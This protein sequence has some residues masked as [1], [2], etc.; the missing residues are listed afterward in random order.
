MMSGPSLAE[1]RAKG[2]P[3]EVL[4]RLNDEHWAVGSTCAGCPRTPP[5]QFA[6]L[7]WSPNAVTVCFM[8]SGAAAGVLTAVPGLRRGGRGGPADPALPA[9]RLLRRGAGQAHRP[10]LRRP[11]IY[12]D[13]MGHYHRGGA[14]AGWPRRPRAG[15]FLAGRR[16]RERGPGG[17]DLR[18]ADQGGDRQRGGG[19]GLVRAERPARRS[20]ARAAVTGTCAGQAAGVGAARAPDHPGRRAVRPHPGRGDRGRGHRHPRPPPGCWSW[21]RWR[22]AR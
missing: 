12:L 19:P 2:Q 7:G 8:I 9:V 4:A 22:W 10:V 18:H 14:A 1:V 11:G 15:S 17:G 5:S 3:P 16:L 13:R 21:R 20:G 6:R